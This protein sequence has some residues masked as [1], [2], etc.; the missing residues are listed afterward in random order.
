MAL[1]HPKCTPTM[2]HT[3][4]QSKI[5]KSTASPDDHIQNHN[6]FNATDS[7]IN[8]TPHAHHQKQVKQTKMLAKLTQWLYLRCGILSDTVGVCEHKI[9]MTK[10]SRFHDL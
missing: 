7:F 2:Q 9:I 3:S 5:K 8:F 10:F 1:K 6:I 4:E